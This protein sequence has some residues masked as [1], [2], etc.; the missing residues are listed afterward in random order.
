MQPEN[1]PLDD[2]VHF[3]GGHFSVEACLVVLNFRLDPVKD[4]WRKGK[5]GGEG[6]R[7]DEAQ[8]QA[9]HRER[10]HGTLLSE[11]RLWAN[12]AEKIPKMES[13]A[14]REDW[15]GYGGQAT[16]AGWVASTHSA[17]I[18][19]MIALRGG[20]SDNSGGA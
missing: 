15:Q 11:D 1:T 19:P 18:S 14:A 2:V 3:L 13:F 5:L 8:H 9:E 4:W 12:R 20:S 17:I 16:R 6:G 7:A 10:F